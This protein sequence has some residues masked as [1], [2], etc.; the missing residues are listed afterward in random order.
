MAADPAAQPN[1]TSS[2]VHR[3]PL[4]HYWHAVARTTDLL[5]GPL[6]R[7][8]LGERIVVWSGPEG[9]PAAAVDQCPH[10]QAPLSEGWRRDDGC[11]VCPYH[12]WTYGA[13]GRCVLVPSAGEGAPVPPKARLA[14][15][16]AV[17]RYGLI[18]TCLDEPVAGIP[19]M[20]WDDDPRFRRLNNPVEDWA[21]SATRMVDNFLDVSHF[22]F[23][24]AGSFGGASDPRVHKVELVELSEGFYGYEYDV[25][26]ANLAGGAATTSGQTTATVS[27]HM[28]SGFVLPFACRSTIAYDTGLEHILLLL[29]TPKDDVSSYFTFVVWR[30]DDFSVPA[31]EVLRLDRMIGAEDKLMLEKVPGS[32]PLDATSLVSVQADRA[33]VEW[34]RQFRLLLEQGTPAATSPA[35]PA[36]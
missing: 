33:S 8:L 7:Q 18:W 12:G 11:L 30:N 27:R 2:F 3:E 17:E 21:T 23:V 32:L 31:D 14:S 4:R 29:S 24:H 5:D 19:D 15:I 22:P 16:H 28:S 13:D 34:R 10:R 25:V 6:A 20:P 35:S 26:A 9:R 1:P 36:S